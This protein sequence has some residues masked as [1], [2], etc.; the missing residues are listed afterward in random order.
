MKN[1]LFAILSLMFLQNANSQQ[2]D[3][4]LKFSLGEYNFKSVYD[5]SGFNSVLK[6]T[7]KGMTLFEREFGGKIYSIKADEFGDDGKMDILID[8]YT[9]GAHCCFNIYTGH[10]EE[11]SFVITDS[12]WLGNSDYEIK[13]LNSDNRRE[14]FA[15]DDRF[16]YAFTNFA[17]TRFSPLVYTVKD[18]KFENITK[19]FP[20][21]INASI[22]ELNAELSKYKNSG[23]KCPAAG[24]DTFNTEAGTMKAILAPLVLDYYNLGEVQKGYDIVNETYT[25]P[26]KGAFT[27]TLKVV[28]KLK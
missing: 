2:D 7:K 26:D 3:N 25:C 13:D 9:G 11:N 19:N 20:E 24:E 12:L 4:P 10:T 23:I 14:I 18:Y 5:T 8:L 22:T 28:Y 1:I 17:E 15:S 21:T 16:A 6:V 27:D